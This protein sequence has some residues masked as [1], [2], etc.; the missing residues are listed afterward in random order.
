VTSQVLDQVRQ[1]V[2]VKRS[3]DGLRQLRVTTT[4]GQVTV[5]GVAQPS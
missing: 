3:F 2:D 5:T 4:E 1:I